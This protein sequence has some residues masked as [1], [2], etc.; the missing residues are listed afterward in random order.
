MVFVSHPY[1]PALGSKE[2]SPV[3]IAAS[4]KNRKRSSAH[5]DSIYMALMAVPIENVKYFFFL[6]K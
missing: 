3:S 4:G 1:G 2:I 6:E 5:S